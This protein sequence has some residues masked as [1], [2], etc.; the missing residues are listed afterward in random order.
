MYHRNITGLK[1]YKA[2]LRGQGLKMYNTD[3][4]SNGNEEIGFRSHIFYIAKL[5]QEE[6]QMILP[7]TKEWKLQVV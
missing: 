3:I 4:A 5:N 7:Q 1:R 6:I 2:D